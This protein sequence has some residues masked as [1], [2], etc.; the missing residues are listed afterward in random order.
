MNMVNHSAESVPQGNATA[1]QVNEYQLA[2]TLRA[3]VE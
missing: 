2:V 1:F 3:L